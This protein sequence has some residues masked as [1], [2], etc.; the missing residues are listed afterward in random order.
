MRTGINLLLWTKHVTEAH[1]HELDLVRRTGFDGAEI[2]IFDGE[3]A[4][5]GK[6]AAILD[7]VGLARTCTSGLDAGTNPIDPDPAVR[8]AAVDRLRW[9]IDCAHALGADVLCGPLHSAFKVFS[10]QG[11]TDD[12]VARSADV[13]REAAEHAESA[14]VLLAIEALNRF[15]CYLVNTASQL[16][17]LCELVDHPSV[18]AHYDTHHM[19]IEERDAGDA[20]L[21]CTPVLGHVHISENDR[22]IP[23]RGQVDWHGTFDALREAGYDGWLVIEA[24]SRL[25]HEFASAIHV[26][27][28]YFLDPE[29]VVQEGLRFIHSAWNG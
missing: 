8:R 17:A 1:E 11:P 5:Y 26:W 21:T 7:R 2:P 28:D 12:E 9:A 3:P 16:R 27:R 10:G 22:G 15:E 19:H 23:G 29:D 13:L 18:R 4:H 24:F 14:G 20:V 25:D 6:L